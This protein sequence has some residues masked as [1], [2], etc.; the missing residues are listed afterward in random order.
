MIDISRF[1]IDQE[2]LRDLPPDWS[3]QLDQGMRNTYFVAYDAD[4]DEMHVWFTQDRD[5]EVLV[6][7]SGLLEI[8][9]DDATEQVIGFIVRKFGEVAAITSDQA[10]KTDDNRS[11]ED[12][13]RIRTDISMHPISPAST[14]RSDRALAGTIK[15]VAHLVAA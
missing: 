9:I 6:P 14:S 4:L 2:A 11:G 15:R 12:I 7:L 3:A 13:S 5:R 1:E 10:A 8:A